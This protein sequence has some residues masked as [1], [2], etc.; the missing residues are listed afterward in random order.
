MS[1][2]EN[3]GT[4]RIQINDTILKDLKRL[5]SKEQLE[6]AILDKRVDKMVGLLTNVQL[7]HCIVLSGC[8]KSLFTMKTK[9]DAKKILIAL[10]VVQLENVFNAENWI[11][12]TETPKK[13]KKPA[14]KKKKPADKKKTPKKKSA[15]EE[16][17]E[18]DVSTKVQSVK[19]K[20]SNASR[21]EAMNA[22]SLT[23]NPMV[24][25]PPSEELKSPRK[26]L[27][28]TATEAFGVEDQ[29]DKSEITRLT[30]EIEKLT[31]ENNMLHRLVGKYSSAFASVM[32]IH[33]HL[34][35]DV[36]KLNTSKTIDLTIVD[37]YNITLTD[38][39]ASTLANSNSAGK[40]LR[41][42]G[43]CAGLDFQNGGASIW[44]ADLVSNVVSFVK[45]NRY[46]KNDDMSKTVLRRKLLGL[47][48]NTRHKLKHQQGN[49]NNDEDD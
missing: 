32:T 10:K 23:T 39:A 28:R 47:A 38:D 40:I 46:P 45:D 25:K 13:K 36:K 37:D 35:T 24:I 41:A 27:K 30:E 1:Q 33:R 49:N 15:D 22:F 14:D 31:A 26:K 9:E 48:H 3:G 16:E 42:V 5:Y 34:A 7:K 44:D 17:L 18:E 8:D 2:E 21:N 6:K 29:N 20:Y 4:E 11:V 12:M 43:A 19:T